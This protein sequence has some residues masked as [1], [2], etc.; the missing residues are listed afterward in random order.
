MWLDT[1]IC[2]GLCVGINRIVDVT[3]FDFIWRECRPPYKINSF[4]RSLGNDLWNV[5]ARHRFECKFFYNLEELCVCVF[6]WTVQAVGLADGRFS[7]KD[8]FEGCGDVDGLGIRKVGNFCSNTHIDR[9]DSCLSIVQAVHE[10]I[11][12][13]VIQETVF[14]AKHRCGTDNSRIREY[15]SYRQLSTS[16]GTVE[17]TWRIEVRV[18][19]RHLYE[20]GH[21]IV[22]CNLSD[23]L[24]AM[25]MDVVVFVV[26]VVRTFTTRRFL[27][28]LCL[29]FSSDKVINNVRVSEAFLDL[30]PI[31]KIKFKRYDLA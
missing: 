25:Y 2:K 13:H 15:L 31:S 14:M 18:E 29:P 27:N 17:S 6:F 30:C 19:M 16:P 22:G 4:C 21:T 23:T 28:S 7:C 9:P 24:G 1:K 12:C 3:T 20:S 11:R 10:W 5:K 26:S 8:S